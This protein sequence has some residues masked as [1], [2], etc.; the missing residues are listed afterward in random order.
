MDSMSVHGGS[1]NKHSRSVE[2]SW[3]GKNLPHKLDLGSQHLRKMLC[4]GLW[5]DAYDP[6]IQG[7]LLNYRASEKIKVETD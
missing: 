2:V 1:R 3:S 7:R 6:C 5:E 4:S